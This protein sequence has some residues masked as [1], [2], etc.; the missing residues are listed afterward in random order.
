[1]DGFQVNLTEAVCLGASLALSGICYYVYRKSRTTVEDLDKAPH[2]TIDRRLKDILKVTPGASL[3]YAVVEGVVKPEGE[4]L[5]SDFHKEISGVLQKFLLREH[6]LVWNG[7]SRRWTDDERVLHERVNTTPFFLVGSDETAVRVLC[8]L[9]ASGRHMEV[10]YERF[11]QVNYGLSDLVGQ[12]LSGQKPKGQLEIEEILKVGTTLTGVGELIVDTDG[13]LNLRPPSDGSEYFLSLGDFDTL[14]G[15]KESEAVCWKTLAVAFAL[16][17]TAVLVWV[18]LRY[19]RCLQ[20][21][22]ELEKERRE[23]ERLQTEAPR[24]PVTVGPEAEGDNHMDNICVICLTQP[25]NCILLDCGHVCCCY[26]C[27]Q[28]L[29]Q[30]RCPICRQRI[31]RV[32]PIYHT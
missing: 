17:G 27:Y 6:R 3:Q 15:E 2:F 1:M 5:K 24:L 16:A 10:I 29:P 19:Y 12:Y 26:T 4:P 31:N 7:F 23:F 25:R 13:T 9:Q 14:R 28:A 22:R 30:C 8:P 21:R 11:H 32:V 20:V 18:G